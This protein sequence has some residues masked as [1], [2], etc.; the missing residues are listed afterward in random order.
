MTAPPSLPVA[1]EARP[2]G[3]RHRVMA[4]LCVLSFLTYFDRVCIVRAQDEIR[5]DLGL[6]TGQMGAV[7]G[8]FWLAYALFELPGGYF[9]DRFGSRPTLTRIVLA[10]S[11]FTALSGSA[12]G[13][14][15]L[16][17]S[18]FLFGV[19]E[20]GAFPNMARVQGRW[21]PVSARARAGGLLFL[22]A[23]WGGALSPLLFGA[24]LRAFGSDAFRRFARESYVL[25]GLAD[26]A[27]WRLSFYAAGLV[28][29]A[30]C[31]LFFV[32]FRDDPARHSGVNAAELA[33]IRSGRTESASSGPS[34][35]WQSLVRS[36][37]LWALGALYLFGSFAWSFFVSWAPTYL[38]AVHHVEMGGSEVMTGLPLFCGG[39]SC[40]LGGASSDAIVRRVGHKRAVRAIFT[41]VGYGS[42]ALAMSALRFA[43]SPEEATCLMC[44]AAAGGD[45]AQGANWATIVDVGGVRAGVAAGLVNMVGNAGNFLQPSI[46]AFVSTSYGWG[47]MFVL[48][49]L[50]Y[51][52]AAAMWFFI[53]PD[54]PF[55][56]A[57]HDE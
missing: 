37:S 17:A 56:T 14:A 33:L 41:A 49:A 1:D 22:L 50:A 30:W 7:F 24:M 15:S 6:T 31:V 39:I 35:P 16:L 18:R 9:G 13:F 42:A 51:V 19:G 44:I 4:F 55:Y 8:A 5:G 47:P 2:S 10:W 26:A 43:R 48:Y 57:P 46:G 34:T 45:F 28:G 11:L 25:R 54:R 20:A 53:D 12:T 38:K 52:I 23:R 29:A 32:W 21:L 3:V 27:A 40:V 36:P